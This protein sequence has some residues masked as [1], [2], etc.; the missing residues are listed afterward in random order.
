MSL[1]RQLCFPLSVCFFHADGG[2]PT[3]ALLSL[4]SY[5][6]VDSI[7]VAFVDTGSATVRR[8]VYASTSQTRS[9]TTTVT[10]SMSPTQSVSPTQSI[11]KTQSRT[12][13]QLPSA[14]TGLLTGVAPGDLFGKSVALSAN[15]GT[16]VVGATLFASANGSA[17]V[18]ACSG[19][20]SCSSAPATT[21]P[22]AGGNFGISV[23]VT[24]NGSVIA[25]GSPDYSSGRG[26]VWVYSCPAGNAVCSTTAV[27][28]LSICC[29]FSGVAYGNTV[30]FSADGT[31]L[32]VGMPGWS[33]NSVFVYSCSGGGVCGSGLTNFNGIITSAIASYAGAGLGNFLAACSAGGTALVV[34]GWPGSNIVPVYRCNS[35]ACSVSPAFTLSGTGGSFFGNSV[36]VSG[37]CSSI[38]VGAP[39]L[40]PQG[41]AYVYTNCLAVGCAG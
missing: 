8:H 9:P 26:G 30:A 28:T 14:A 15:G 16:L 29:G 38:V 40:S 10:Q 12:V 13:T 3:A 34:A 22:G 39:S 5:I 31:T 32:A 20:G 2:S 41:A 24:G 6:T 19:A 1:T 37:D 7:G 11:S 4:P 23:S 36:A 27:S 17:F 33:G 18:F 25:V 21:L 35:T